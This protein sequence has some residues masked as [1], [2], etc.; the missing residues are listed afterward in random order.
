MATPSRSELYGRALVCRHPHSHNL[1][2]VLAHAYFLTS[3]GVKSRT[4]ESFCPGCNFL[5]REARALE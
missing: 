1:R 3:T 4:K 2:D 5:I